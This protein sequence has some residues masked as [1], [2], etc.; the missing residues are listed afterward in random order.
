MHKHVLSPIFGTALG[1]Y[2]E[3]KVEKMFL[4]RSSGYSILRL[5]FG[6]QQAFGSSSAFI[7]TKTFCGLNLRSELHSF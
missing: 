6:K 3:F 4:I 5:A 2:S 7:L 1:L